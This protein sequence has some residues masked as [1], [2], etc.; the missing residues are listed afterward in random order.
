MEKIVYD[1]DYMDQLTSPLTQAQRD[2]IFRW[3]SRE[4]EAVRI[5]IA[6]RHGEIVQKL[7]K[8]REKNLMPEF[9]LAAW[10]LAIHSVKEL[11]GPKE[12]KGKYSAEELKALEALSVARV[13]VKRKRKEG[14]VEGKIRKAY[15]HVITKLREEENFSWRDLGEYLKKTFKMKCSYGHLRRA[16]KKIQA[17]KRLAEDISVAEQMRV[18]YQELAEENIR[19]C[20]DFKF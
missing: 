9:H 19:I 7:W 15:Y 1:L 10:T 13:K 17:E 20:E 16:Y 14:P 11:L 5:E 12:K 6:R 8:Q 3:F 4:P 2:K 18:A